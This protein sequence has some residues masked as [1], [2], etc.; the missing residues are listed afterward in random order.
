MKSFSFPFEKVTK[1][2]G[3]KLKI[4][5][6]KLH[7]VM[8]E[9]SSKNRELYAY[10][11]ALN[12]TKSELKEILI[13]S[14]D[15]DKIILYSIAISNTEKILE[16]ILKELKELEKE[17]EKIIHEFMRLNSEKKALEKLKDKLWS[18]YLL[19]YSKYENLE[20]S[21]TSYFRYINKR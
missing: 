12:K 7:N 21:D 2:T 19:D 14:L 13:G 6:T 20:S 4:V 10:L 16:K 5:E 9:I 17:K 8:A 1:V 15:I 11:N 3:Q 18:K